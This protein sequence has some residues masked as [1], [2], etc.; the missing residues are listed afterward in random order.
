[1]TRLDLRDYEYDTKDLERLDLK[2]FE[3][4]EFELRERR[5]EF[6]RR[7]ATY[8]LVKE[9]DAIVNK[10]IPYSR[11]LDLTNGRDVLLKE[12][13]LIE[14]AMLMQE[15]N[16]KLLQ[17][18]DTWKDLERKARKIRILINKKDVAPEFIQLRRFDKAIE[19][20]DEKLQRRLR[21]LRAGTRQ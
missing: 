12:Y 14:D 7:M 10:G 6:K 2:S 20:S 9:H 11:Y 18:G 21:K 4:S 8:M 3:I 13:D 1:M 16:H 15:L 19:E 5:Y 17:E